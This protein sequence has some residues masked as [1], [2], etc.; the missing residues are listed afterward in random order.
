MLPQLP[1]KVK[2]FFDSY[3]SYS[4]M[5]GSSRGAVIDYDFFR[6]LQN[7]TVVKELCVVSASASKSSVSS[8]LQDG[9]SRLD[10]ERH[11]LD[12]WAK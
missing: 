12:G 6:G 10:S 7:G 9:R 11:K 5:A 4:N 3:H 1:I 8:P 2:C